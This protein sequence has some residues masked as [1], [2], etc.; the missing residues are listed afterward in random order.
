MTNPIVPPVTAVNHAAVGFT[1]T[2]ILITFG[3]TRVAMNDAGNG[4]V[5]VTPFVEW[6]HTASICP[7]AA[8]QLQSTLTEALMRYTNQFGAIPTDKTFMQ[9]LDPQQGQPQ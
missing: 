4:N 2:E 7:T 6:L 3:Q 5:G 9:R 1:P 8:L